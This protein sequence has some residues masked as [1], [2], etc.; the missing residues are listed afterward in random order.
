MN[1]FCKPVSLLVSPFD[2]NATSIIY[3]THA[4]RLALAIIMFT[5]SPYVC[6]FVW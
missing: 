4:P 5:E 3:T 6:I 1:R 2:L